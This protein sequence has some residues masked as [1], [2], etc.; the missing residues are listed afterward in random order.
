[1]KRR[2]FLTRASAAVA[3]TGL[4][5][6]AASAA[7]AGTGRRM[8]T[9]LF[10]SMFKAMPLKA[11]IENAAA[12]GYDGIALC[13]IRNKAPGREMQSSASSRDQD[14]GRDNNLRLC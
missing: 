7:K 8:K 10:S 1:M 3:F 5:C 6:T 2:E 4:G 12:I 14:G 11:A 13:G 9:S